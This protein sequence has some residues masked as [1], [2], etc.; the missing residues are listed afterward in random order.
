MASGNEW[1][2]RLEFYQQKAK[3]PDATQLGSSAGIID[4][5]DFSAVILQFGYRFKL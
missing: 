4:M 1:S 5:P 3:T 2:A